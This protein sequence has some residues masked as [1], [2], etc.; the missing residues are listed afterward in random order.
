M[1]RDEG[2][3]DVN[4]LHFSAIWPLDWDSVRNMLVGCER[5]VAVES[6]YTGQLCELIARET[7]VEI[8]DRILKYD[9]RPMTPNYIIR[10][11]SGVMGW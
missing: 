9:G 1:L 8:G 7:C 3:A 2:H 4:I 5:L 11:L 6:N 10:H